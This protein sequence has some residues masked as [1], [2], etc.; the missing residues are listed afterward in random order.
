MTR[1]AFFD[2]DRT[3]IRADSQ[4]EEALA[5]LGRPPSLFY[6]LRLIPVALAEPFYKRHLMSHDQFN[7]FYLYSYKGMA[8]ANLKRHALTLYQ[9]RLRP[10][11]MDATLQKI[12]AHRKKGDKIVIL[13]ATSRHL[14]E[15][16]IDEIKPDGWAATDIETDVRGICT[17]RAMG[18]I[19]VHHEK[20]RAMKLLARK[21]HVSCEASVAS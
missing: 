5:L 11:L 20:A 7:A 4:R 17:G 9:K 2:F 19:C 18:R 3:L 6:P 14:I 16:F 13:S 21:L 8:L 15:P 12:E 10:K 1:A